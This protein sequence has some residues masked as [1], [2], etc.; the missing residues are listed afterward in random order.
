E[1][2][3]DPHCCKK[4]TKTNR[5]TVCANKHLFDSSKSS[6]YVKEWTVAYGTGSAKGFQGKDT[7]RFGDIGTNPLTVPGCTFGQATHLASF[8]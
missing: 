5:N 1:I 4:A 8:F 3:C 7:V 6:T 2:E